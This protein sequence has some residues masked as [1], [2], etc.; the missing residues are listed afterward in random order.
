MKTL[1]FFWMMMGV[2]LATLPF[3]SCLD[4]DG[5]SPGDF[6][7]SI[8]TVESEESSSS[9]Y[10]KLD[11]GT[12]LWPAAGYYL[13]HNLENRQRI[14]L[15]YTILSDSL[16]GYSHY[17]KVND[18]D[19]VLTKPIAADKFAANDSIY[20]TD[21]VEIK[22][23]WIGSGFLNILFA[24]NYGGQVKHFVN[25]VKNEQDEM[26]AGSYKLEFR[27]N[28]YNDPALSSATG[29]VCFDLG[30]LTAGSM[31]VIKFTLAV[32]TFEG[33]KT[34]TF[35]YDPKK[36]GETGPKDVSSIHSGYADNV[37]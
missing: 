13:G 23:M 36:P 34:Y 31:E 11:D 17:V 27:H 16:S 6:W 10:F 35:E 12:T 21:P 14:I 29:P 15:N 18:I 2:V 28:A 5:Y 7:V 19:I 3:Q 24:A 33:D 4:D 25:L 30:S 1:N 37:Q 8:A 20:G 26:P 32:K 9:H 22:Q